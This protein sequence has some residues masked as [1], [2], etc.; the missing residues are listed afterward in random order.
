MIT[1]NNSYK[2]YL[3]KDLAA[4]QLKKVSFYNY[5]WKDCLRFQLRLRKIEYLQNVC[6]SNYFCR[7]Y[8]FLLE[9]IN[10]RLATRLGFS[11]PKN[12]CGGGLCIVHYGTIVI[13]PKAKIGENFRIHPSTSIGD[14]NGAP[15]IGNNVYVGPGAKLFGNITVGNNV[16]IGANAVVN[17]DIPDNVTVG[18]IPAK[19]IS[20][21]SSLEKGV[22]PDAILY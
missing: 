8:L 9:Y 3:K 18:G 14:Y 10:H 22:F 6:R 16:A 5:W 21:K 20:H 17:T 12:V 13:S 11:I 15:Q 1:D 19:I 2:D 7:I 4:Y